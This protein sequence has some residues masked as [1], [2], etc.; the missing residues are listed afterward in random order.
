MTNFQPYVVFS[1]NCY[2]FYFRHNNYLNKSKTSKYINKASSKKSK[3]PEDEQMVHDRNFVYNNIYSNKKWKNNSDESNKSKYAD[4]FQPQMSKLIKNIWRWP[5]STW[6][7]C[8]DCNTF[9]N[10]NT[11]R[12]FQINLKN[13]NNH[14]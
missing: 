13:Q 10:N 6:S 2:R 11:M 1:I 14:Y 3:T 5:A 7:K 9:Y 12:T 4:I 8:C